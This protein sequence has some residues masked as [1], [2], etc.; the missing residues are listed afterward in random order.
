MTEE[1]LTHDIIDDLIILGH[2]NPVE[3]KG[4]RKSICTVGYSPTKGLVRL[5]PVPIN[6]R[7]KMWDILKL[8]VEKNPQDIR[9]ESWKIQNS[10]KDWDVLFKKVKHIDKV[11]KRSEKINMIEY[12]YQKYGQKCVHDLNE[13]KESLGLIKPKDVE[14]YFQDRAYVESTIQI[15][16]DSST[17]YKTSSNYPLIPKIKYRCDCCRAKSPHNQQLLEWG[18]YQWIRKNPSNPEQIW[19]NYHLDDPDWQHYFLVGN[20]ARHPTSFMVIGILRY[21][22]EL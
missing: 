19:R 1:K 17:A 5:Y 9:S 14:Y 11:K 6:V 4:A 7:P 13:Q 15:T 18:A 12:L 21:K 22:K 3:I 20:M 8:P 2:A 16:L 10:N